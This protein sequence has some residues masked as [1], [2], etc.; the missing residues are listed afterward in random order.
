MILSRQKIEKIDIDSV[1]NDRIVTGKVHQTLFIVPTRRKIRYFTRELITYSTGKAV[2]GLNI[3]TLGSYSQR[4]L[5]DASGSDKLISDEVSI[6][7][8]DQCFSEIKPGYFSQY[9]DHIPS[10]TLQRIKNV[11]SEYKRQGISPETIRQESV[12]LQGAE[13]IKALDIAAVFE[14]YQSKLDEL[15]LMEIGDVYS[16]LI[17]LSSF[18][19]EKAFKK[20]YPDVNLVLVNGFDEFTLPETEI[21]STTA[22]ISGLELFVILDYYRFNPLIFSHLDLCYNRF[23]SKGFFE[24]K[25]LSEGSQ[26]DFINTV[27]ENLSLRVLPEPIKSFSE[28]L[29]L[30]NASGRE[31]EIELVAKQIKTLLNSGKTEPHKICVVFNLISKYSPVI[32]DIFPVFGI[33]FNLTDRFHLNNSEPIKGIIHLLEVAE[34]DFYYKSIIRSQSN[35]FSKIGDVDLSNLLRIAVKLKIVSGLSAWISRINESKLNNQSGYNLNSRSQGQLENLNRAESDLLKIKILLDPFC[36]QLTPVEFKESIFLLIQKLNITGKILSMP[37]DTIE[38]DLKAIITLITSLNELTDMLL[39]QYGSKAK[40]DLK[41][42]L[43]QLRTLTAFSRYNVS[44]KPGYG[45][46]VTTLNE[47]RGLKFDYVFICGLND[48][49]FPTR[50]SPEVFFSGSFAKEEFRHQ[51]E[52]RYLFYQ[53]LCTFKKGLILSSPE[54]EES[55]ELARSVFLKDFL[56]LF[57]VPVKEPESF[58]D[59]IFSKKELLE[60]IGRLPAEVRETIKIPEELNV[61]LK[62]ILESIKVDDIRQRDMFSASVHTGYVGENADGSPKEILRDLADKEFSATQLETYAKCPYKFFLENI[63]RIETSEEPLEELEEFEYGSL[64]HQVLYEFYTELA[65]ENINIKNCSDADF[66]KAEDLLFKLAE[67][68]FNE[69]NLSSDASF[70]EREKVMGIGGRRKDSLLYKF[71]EE[72]RNEKDEFVPS[73]FELGFGGIS[74]PNSG[75]QSGRREIKAGNVKLRG[76]IDRIDIDKDSDLFKVIDYKSGSEIPTGEELKSGLSLQLPIYL[77]AA[78]QLIS[79][80]LGKDLQPAGAEI[81]SLKYAEKHFGRKP[82]RIKRKSGEESIRERSSQAEEMILSSVEVINRYVNDISEGRFNLS[83]LKDREIKVCRYC[84]F[85][86]ICRIQE[87]K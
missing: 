72:E 22:D 40:F 11:I 82:I 42:F 48:G 14:K 17:K 5:S 1:I 25:D 39:L 77:Y 87:V 69:L 61:D 36:K 67:E 20:F 75:K 3:E 83:Q 81:F 4:L 26:S 64:I 32:R 38:K 85:K 57:E 59:V 51:V 54:F 35:Y 63:L 41:Y 55:K 46:L 13:K 50:F 15:K 21:I 27:K 56:S 65:K 19:Y 76:K 44:E 79:A 86:K 53:A 70:L 66:K 8:L 12:K 49:D 29:L 80:E 31:E 9:K 34:N 16:G 10:G 52:E 47:I 2:F 68:K 58:A 23:L 74:D 33:P 78:K 60:Y 43:D 30:I 6:L 62:K 37:V 45:V 18:D 84:D 28:K 71:L 7:L 73:F 24:V